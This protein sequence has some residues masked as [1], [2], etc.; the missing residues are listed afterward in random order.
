MGYI[1]NE[2]LVQILKHF[3]QKPI[4]FILIYS[5]LTLRYVEITL[6]IIHVYYFGGGEG[7]ANS[8]Y[9]LWKKLLRAIMAM[10]SFKAPA[11]ND[12]QAFFYKSLWPFMANIFIAW[13]RK[14]F[15]DGREDPLLLK[16]LIV[17]IPMVDNPFHLKDLRPIILY[18]VAYK[19]H[20]GFVKQVQA[21][22]WSMVV[23][24]DVMVDG[25]GSV[26]G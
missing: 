5:L 1:G 23:E 13:L 21:E 22:S 12:F 8:V 17:L 7:D 4:N 19:E 24:E 26:V 20:K 16:T 2:K 10:H 15:E 11:T 3:I 6:W 14:L 18:D 25:D 9:G